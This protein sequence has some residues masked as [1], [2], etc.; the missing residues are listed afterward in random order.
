MFY[1]IATDFQAKSAT[2]LRIRNEIYYFLSLSGKAS[3]PPQKKMIIKIHEFKRINNSNENHAPI[4]I[5]HFDCSQLLTHTGLKGKKGFFFSVAVVMKLLYFRLISLF[6][7][8]SRENEIKIVFRSLS[9][10][11][12]FTLQFDMTS[13]IKQALKWRPK[14]KAVPSSKSY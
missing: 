8:H 5:F 1:M 3:F 4:H 14:N 7:I 13:R 10:N 6:H 9:C 2:R 12:L 11:L